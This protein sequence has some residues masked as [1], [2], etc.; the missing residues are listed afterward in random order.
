MKYLFPFA[1]IA[2]LAALFLTTTAQATEICMGLYE[3][4]YGKAVTGMNKNELFVIC[5]NCPAYQRLTLKPKTT[6]LAVRT[7]EAQVSDET[8]TR[9]IPEERSEREPNMEHVSVTSVV[10]RSCIDCLLPV[11]FRFDRADLSDYERDQL[12]RMVSCTKGNFTKKP[13]KIQI[14][15]YTCDIG[16]QLHNDRLALMRAKSVAAY[17]ERNGFYIAEVKG[18]GMSHPLS[19]IRSLNRRVEIEIIH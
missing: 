4:N 16:S 18:E 11:Y 17:L 10:S 3:Y 12:D 8:N 1:S 15:G 2:F 6:A 13:L 14:R 5:E 7:V 19:R 9:D